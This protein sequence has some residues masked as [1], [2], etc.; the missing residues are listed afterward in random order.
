MA[1]NI[2]AATAQVHNLILISRNIDDFKALDVTIL[3]PFKI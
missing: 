1:D 3:N 2:I